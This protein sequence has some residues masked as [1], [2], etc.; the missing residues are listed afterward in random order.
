MTSVLALLPFQPLFDQLLCNFLS[1]LHGFVQG[2]KGEVVL[3]VHQIISSD[4]EPAKPRLAAIGPCRQNVRL[5]QE[6]AIT[7]VV[8]NIS[9]LNHA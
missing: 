8:S 6:P 5:T 2:A 3:L 9:V 1:V 4:R 7:N